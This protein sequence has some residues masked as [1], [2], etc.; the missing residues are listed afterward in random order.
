MDAV[1]QEEA[2]W[3]LVTKMRPFVEAQDPSAKV[4]IISFSLLL[5][6]IFFLD[7]LRVSLF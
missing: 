3:E 7:L 2:E 1:D 5:L 4:L 6:I